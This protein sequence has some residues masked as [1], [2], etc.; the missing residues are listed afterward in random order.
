MPRATPEDLARPRC[1]MRRGG[2][3]DAIDP[4]E[5]ESADAAG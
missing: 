4:D 3:F 5:Q 1:H 2:I